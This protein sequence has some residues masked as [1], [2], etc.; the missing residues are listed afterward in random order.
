MYLQKIC[1]SRKS[2]NLLLHQIFDE[3]Y[4]GFCRCDWKKFAKKVEINVHSSKF[5]MKY[6]VF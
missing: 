2:I 6:Y 4:N 1:F 3:V 5:L